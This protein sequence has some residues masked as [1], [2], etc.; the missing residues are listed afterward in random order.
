MGLKP[1]WL[2]LPGFRKIRSE[3]LWVIVLK[4]VLFNAGE[5]LSAVDRIY[6]R[7]SS[8]V[9]KMRLKADWGV[10]KT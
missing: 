7:R 5:K 4:G 6:G 3:R 8:P 9:N 2:R 10:V 1:I